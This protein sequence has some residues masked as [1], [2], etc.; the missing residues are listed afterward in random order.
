MKNKT[1]Y[2]LLGLFF[3][4]TSD[5]FETSGVSE[6]NLI[7]VRLIRHRMSDYYNK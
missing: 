2:Q 7:S 5:V 3:N 4:Q 1:F 6:E